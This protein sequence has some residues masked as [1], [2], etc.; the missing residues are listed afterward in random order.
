MDKD[1]G[2]RYGHALHYEWLNSVYDLTP[3]LRFLG[4]PRISPRMV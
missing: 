1:G 3:I 2:G 4:D